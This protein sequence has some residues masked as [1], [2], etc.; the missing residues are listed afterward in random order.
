MSVT[1]V[2]FT[3][4]TSRRASRDQANKGGARG[5]RARSREA[6]HA[7]LKASAT[8]L[9][10]ARGLRSVTTHDIAREAGVATGTF[11]L[12]FKDKRALLRDIVLESLGQLR[13]ALD[14]AAGTCEGPEGVRRRVET[15]VD[16]AERKHEVVRIL[17]SRD[18]EWAELQSLVLDTFASEGE[19]ALRS[20]QVNS[21]LRGDLDAAVA[22]QGVTGML[23]RVID[24]W[25]KDP[26]RAPREQIVETIVELQTTG[27]YPN[28][29][30]GRSVPDGARATNP[31]AQETSNA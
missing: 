16:F 6:T 10:A 26:S 15:V 2:A 13:A 11:Y 12:H 30:H 24:W 3:S 8:R 17:F 7:R 14:L 4:E 9:F 25:S 1:D 5:A 18:T 19:T 31:E 28:L 22:A 27:L 23:A 20:Q 21:G 29:A